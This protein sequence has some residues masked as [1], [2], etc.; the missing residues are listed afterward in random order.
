MECE[1]KVIK[2]YLCLFVTVLPIVGSK[3][4]GKYHAHVSS[5]D[6]FRTYK[7]SLPKVQRNYEKLGSLPYV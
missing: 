7:S 2:V 6:G 1:K 3:S 5:R 4:G